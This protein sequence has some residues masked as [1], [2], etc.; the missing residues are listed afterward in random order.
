MNKI[1]LRN[2]V[3]VF[4]VG[5]PMLFAHGFGCDQNMWRF[6]TPAFEKDYQIVLFDYVGSGNSDIKA[7]NKEKYN[8]LQGYANDVIDVVNALDLKDVIFVGHSVSSMIGL[9]AAI[10]QPGSFDKMIFIGPSARYINESPAYVGGFE[11]K[12]IL[13]LL[14]T[15]EK[16]YI[17]WANFLAP[18][19]MKNADKPGLGQELTESFCSTDPVIARQFAEVTF[20]SD[21]RND[22]AKLKIP[23]LL[24]QCSDDLIAPLEVGHYLNQQMPGS[25][26]KIMKATGHCPHMSAPDETILLMKEY[27]SSNN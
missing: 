19:I 2:N 27:L 16:N 23:A 22:L 8:D 11:K 17:G 21:N 14:D 20:L 4:G 3:K 25:T 9:L 1:L 5:Q 13:E 10:K 6:I 26:L 12:D 15:M 7:Y 18:A 24:L